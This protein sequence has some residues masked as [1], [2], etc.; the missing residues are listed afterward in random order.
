MQHDHLIKSIISRL[1]LSRC[2]QTPVKKSA[3]LVPH[4]YSD[5]TDHTSPNKMRIVMYR[6][7]KYLKTGDEARVL[8]VRTSIYSW[9]STYI[10]STLVQVP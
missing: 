6:A 10:T 2:D 4:G 5:V 1:S 7:P 8:E 3:R 9:G